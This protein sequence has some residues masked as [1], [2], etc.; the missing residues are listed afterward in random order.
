MSRADRVDGRLRYTEPPNQPSVRGRPVDMAATGDHS[1]LVGAGNALTVFGTNG[2]EDRRV[3][4]TVRFG[5][6]VGRI[7]VGGHGAWVGLPAGDR[8]YQINL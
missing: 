6:T 2:S 1:I 5:T 8:V 3:L 4:A 7:A